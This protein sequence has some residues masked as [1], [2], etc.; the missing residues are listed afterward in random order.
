MKCMKHHCTAR[1]WRFGVLLVKLAS[2]VRTFFEENGITTTVNSARYIDIINNFLE[3]ELRGYRLITKCVVS[4]RW[5]HRS[6]CQSHNGCCLNHVPWSPHFTMWCSLA[7]SVPD[8]SI[9]SFFLWFYL[10]SHVYK[11]KPRTLE[12]KKGAILKQIGMTNQELLERVEANFQD[13]LQ[14]CI[15]QNGHHL[16][17]IFSYIN[18]LKWHVITYHFVILLINKFCTKN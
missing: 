15:L 11:G 6:H 3:P 9:C 7:S 12:E 14:M 4:A 10:K 13:R 5:G 18:S 8:L 1:K 16:S 2:L 17:D